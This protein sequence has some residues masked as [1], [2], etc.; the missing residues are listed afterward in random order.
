MKR[1]PQNCGQY[2]D[3]M[4][5]CP[6]CD[7]LLIKTNKINNNVVPPP[8]PPPPG[9][10]AKAGGTAGAYGGNPTPPVSPPNPVPYQGGEAS[11]KQDCYPLKFPPIV[12]GRVKNLR[13]KLLRRPTLVKAFESLTSGTPLA[14]GDMVNTFQVFKQDSMGR[15]AEG[16]Q[17]TIYG[18]I[19]DG[20]LY[21]GN[22]VRV[23]GKAPRGRS[24]RATTVYN[25]T[26]DTVV[27]IG[28]VSAGL[29]RGIAGI[30]GIIL[31]FV[32]SNLA[33]FAAMFSTLLVYAVLIG[34]II[35]GLKIYFTRYFLG[36]ILGR[37]E[38]NDDQKRSW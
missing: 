27:R 18:E 32:L 9:N 21:E 33:V 29:I 25:V 14:S 12:E 31:L 22:T 30:F 23:W 1:C 13:T 37:K 36:G 4:R 3:T 8:P 15:D 2:A 38:N 17:V 26:S 6:R 7:S 35:F 5:R 19:V 20:E 34:A 28:G 16:F 11:P 10:A 24:I